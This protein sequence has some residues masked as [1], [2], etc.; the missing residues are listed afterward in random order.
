[1][2]LRYRDIDIYMYHVSYKKS[3]RMLIANFCRFKRQKYLSHYL[4]SYI[5]FKKKEIWES[6]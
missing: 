3:I 1:M 6:L 5:G 2:F 4:I